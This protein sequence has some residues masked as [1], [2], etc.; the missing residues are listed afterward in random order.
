[1]SR[2]PCATPHHRIGAGQ[3]VSGLAKTGVRYDDPS[4]GRFTHKAQRQP[5]LKR[6]RWGE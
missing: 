6:R 2:P 1:M 3:D 5:P 4:T